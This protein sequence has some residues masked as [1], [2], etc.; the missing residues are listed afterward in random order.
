[1]VKIRIAFPEDALPLTRLCRD[2]LGY[3]YPPERLS[4]K[5]A[6]ISADPG[7][8]VFVAVSEE[9]LPV[10]F[11]HTQVYDVLYAPTML[12]ILGLAVDASC[13]RQGIGR[14]LLSAAELDAR[15]RGIGG[16]RLV[17]GQER[18]GAHRFYEQ[19]GYQRSKTQLNLKKKL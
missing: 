6:L 5:L 14:A 1:M 16:V 10:G 4:E 11:I 15:H 3:D 7:Q 19:N 9:G 17:S 8:R 18:T 13:R 12:N 2:A